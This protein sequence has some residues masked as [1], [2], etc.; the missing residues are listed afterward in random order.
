MFNFAASMAFIMS[1]IMLAGFSIRNIIYA[2][3]FA[4]LGYAAMQMKEGK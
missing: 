1:G 2:V 3:V 4:M